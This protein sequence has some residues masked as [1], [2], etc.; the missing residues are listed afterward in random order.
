[1]PLAKVLAKIQYEG[2]YVDKEELIS[3]GEELKK[4]I[5]ELTKEIYSLA[6]EEFN[7]NSTGQLGNILF[8]KLNL[9]TSKKT[10]KGY[11]TDV[12]ALEKIRKE[13]PIVEKILEYR[14]LMKLNSTYVEGIL[15]YINEK[16]KRIH[17]YFHQTV[18]ATGRIS[19]AEPNLQNIP[20]RFELGKN[21]RKVF[22]PRPRLYLYRRRLFAN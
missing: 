18:T 12:D 16:T 22:K 8:E 1:M 20:T 4:G 21:L 2:M 13:H 17:S 6:G 3:F 7:I 14:S 10:K 9:T 5:E 11:S 15:P 19:S